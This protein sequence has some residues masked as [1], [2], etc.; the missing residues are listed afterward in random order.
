MVSKAFI[1]IR[2]SNGIKPVD[3]KY[4]YHCIFVVIMLAFQIRGDGGY[5]LWNSIK[6]NRKWYYFS[7]EYLYNCQW[8]CKPT[9]WRHMALT[10]FPSTDNP[11][12]CSKGGLSLQQWKHER[13][14]L[15]G[16]YEETV[17][18]LVVS[19]HKRVCYAGKVSMPYH[20]HER[21]F[22]SDN[23]RFASN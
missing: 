7:F 2:P 22:M 6:G 8:Q 15:M 14:V 23:D 1:I 18:W 21:S 13:S 12:F 10:T 20:H 11:I 16:L 3:A 5:V 4:M 19:R 9:H 17:Q